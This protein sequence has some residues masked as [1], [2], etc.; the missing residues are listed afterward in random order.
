MD[1]MMISLGIA[2]LGGIGLWTI[3]KPTPQN[4]KKSSNR[5]VVGGLYN[6]GNTCFMNSCIQGFVSLPAFVEYLELQNSGRVTAAMLN[7]ANYLEISNQPR[8]TR[9]K[10]LVE[11]LSGKGNTHLLGYQ[12]QDAHEFF[13]HVS[14]LIS[15]EGDKARNPRLPSLFDLDS[16]EGDMEVMFGNKII[17]WT[18]ENR[19]RNPL[20]GLIASQ[21]SCLQCGLKSV[22]RHDTFD[23]L[24]LTTPAQSGYHIRDLLTEYTSAEMIHGY[25]CDKCSLLATKKR[26]ERDI[27]DIVNQA[28]INT[29]GT[30]MEA[31]QDSVE[32]Q[33]IKKTTKKKKKTKSQVVNAKKLEKK[34]P[35]SSSINLDSPSPQ[36]AILKQHLSFVEESISM[37]N[38]DREFPSGLEKIK[39]SSPT[40]KQV[41]VAYAPP[42]L[43][44][45][46]QRS[47]YLPSGHSVKNNAAVKFPDTLDLTDFILGK[48]SFASVQSQIL[49]A[50]I[51]KQTVVGLES[52]EGIQ[53]NSK[54][55]I[56]GS[57]F[58]SGS[59]KKCNYTLCS[60]IL[61][62]GHH[63]GGHFI[64]LRKVKYKTN[65]GIKI[66]WFRISDANVERITDVEEEVFEHGSRF[67]FML[68]Y[69]QD[70]I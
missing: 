8:T 58:N 37:Q 19:M 48:R 49:Q 61:H 2:V 3:T 46:M 69:Q 32:S 55:P 29:N 33:P 40:T 60:V 50:A 70:I 12:Q 22:K 15:V 36:L 27:Q 17:K 42:C 9:P 47:M 52:K 39:I 62:Y 51:E 25:I 66:L 57:L 31:S 24:S 30:T 41:S 13:Q 4:S 44:L 35:L 68:F 64:T 23:N 67:A 11:A 43:C 28:T 59:V 21:I 10:E 56:S 20:L 45:H 5:L 7:L 38:Y 63:E 16:L 34:Q 18:R 1:S 26:I 6:E 14:N 54:I 65:N 53:V